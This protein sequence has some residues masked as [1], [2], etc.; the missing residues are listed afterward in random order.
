MITSVVLIFAMILLERIIPYSRQIRG[1]QDSLQAYYTAQGEVEMAKNIFQ[2]EVVRK[3]IDP[4]NRIVPGISR[5]IDVA[6]P[7]VSATDTG[8]YVII[9]NHNEIP[10]QI[11]M[12]ERDTSPRGFGTSQKNPGFHALTQYGW[13]MLFDL[14]KRDT[15]TP[16]FSMIAHTDTDNAATVG[17]IQTEFVY[18]DWSGS[19]P[20]FGVVGSSVAS[21]LEGKNIANSLD[22]NR[23][24]GRDTLSY[25]FSLQ[26]C[27]NGSCALKLHLKDSTAPI[28]PV[29]FSVSTALPDL[30]AVLIADGLSPNATYHARIVELIPLVQSI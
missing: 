3:N 14:T 4:S 1:M 19:T 17:N 28:L 25:L 24:V 21:A 2:K 8:D 13:G 23:E 7:V 26:N 11:N 20:F 9:S 30:N 18:T 5:T 16:P 12:F 15:S 22:T 6:M 29:S 27:N 10:L